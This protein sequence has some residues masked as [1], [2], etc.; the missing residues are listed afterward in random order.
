ME[1]EINKQKVI[2]LTV[3]IEQVS[4]ALLRDPDGEDRRILVEKLKEIEGEI[5]KLKAILKN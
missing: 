5:N 3:L 4:L 1:I 2:E